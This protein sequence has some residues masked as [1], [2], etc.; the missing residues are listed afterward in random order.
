MHETKDHLASEVT[1]GGNG[2]YWRGEPCG[3][4]NRVTLV[5]GNDACSSDI[6]HRISQAICDAGAIAI[7]LPEDVPLEG[8]RPS[9]IVEF[10][11]AK[12]PG[13]VDFL[14]TTDI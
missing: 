8:Q 11:E 10:L 3:V 2:S 1:V 6:Q 13:S 5:G 12:S 4:G 14:I 9:D 7:T